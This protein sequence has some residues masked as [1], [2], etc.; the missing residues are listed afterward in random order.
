[1]MLISVYVICIQYK[2]CFPVIYAWQWLRVQILCF[3][4]RGSLGWFMS[5]GIDGYYVNFYLRMYLGARI[6]SSFCG[7]STLMYRTMNYQSC[8]TITFI[9]HLSPHAMLCFSLSLS[10]SLSL[11]HSSSSRWNFL[12]QSTGSIVSRASASRRWGSQSLNFK[13]KRNIL[14]W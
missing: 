10:L 13:W 6:F 9:K 7:L 4:C 14:L 12:R 5:R 1:M 11:F 2:L 8:N 3:C